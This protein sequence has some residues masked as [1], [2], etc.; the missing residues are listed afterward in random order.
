MR[1]PMAEL[2]DK[3]ILVTGPAGQIAF[4]LARDLARSNE[5][6][7]V[8]RFSQ[9]GSRE[10]VEKAG[11]RAATLNSTLSPDEARSVEDALATRFS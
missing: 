10:R 6:W 8:A 1:T 2:R 11:V 3:R 4:P 7:G 5:V 9:P